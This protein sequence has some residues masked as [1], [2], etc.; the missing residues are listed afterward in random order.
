MQIEI[1]VPVWGAAWLKP[2]ARH[3]LLPLLAEADSIGARV[4]IYTDA[5]GAAWLDR[6]SD[7]LAYRMLPAPG[8]GYLDRADAAHRDA[9]DRALAGG[10][11]VSPVAATMV[12]GLG[13]YAAARR[14]L[15]A[16]Y[17]AVMALT[18]QRCEPP[19]AATAAAIS[20]WMAD[21]GFA[22]WDERGADVGHP[23]Y[24]AW[25]AGRAVLVRPLYI[26]PILLAPTRPHVPTRAHD[27]FMV[28]G[29][30]DRVEQVACLDPIDG[31][32][33]AL[34]PPA[35]PPSGAPPVV[36]RAT[37][38]AR[39]PAPTAAIVD[40]MLR[41]VGDAGPNIRRWNLHYMAH[42]FWYGEPGAARL[43]VE[44]ASDAVVAAL[45]REYEK[46]TSEAT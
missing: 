42:R 39:P 8:P 32:F 1:A 24:F 38:P 15:E 27:H 30:L 13:S 25:R 2:F 33:A 26:P 23:G 28:E 45:T 12:P 20:A 44:R 35:P 3:A 29:Y 10:Y 36:P 16:G 22:S 14:R 31:C 7:R 18:L 46:R 9:I 19:A 6:V 5:A 43:E 34:A 37:A 17:R 41:P 40:W 21:A 11:A 4:V